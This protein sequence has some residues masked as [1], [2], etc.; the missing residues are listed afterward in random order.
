MEKHSKMYNILT[1]LVGIMLICTLISC[2]N[3]TGGS[4]GGGE[5]STGGNQDETPIIPTNII[6]TGT[7]DSQVYSLKITD[8][9][10]SAN[11]SRA[12]YTPKINDNYV[13]TRGNQSNSG[14][15]LSISGSFIF[16]LKQTGSDITFAVTITDG[17][18]SALAGTITWTNLTPVN[19]IA[20]DFYIENLT[21]TAENIIPVTIIPK[22]GKSTGEITVLYNESTTLPTE[23]GT[24]TVTF[25]VTASAGWNAVNGLTG[26]TLSINSFNQN[27]VASDF[28]ISN[29]VQTA[30]SV[31]PVTITPQTGKS[32]GTITVYYDWSSNLPTASGTYTVTFDVEAA[33]GWNAAYQLNGGTLIINNQ[34]PVANDFFISNL[35]QTAGSVT[36]VAITPKAGK[37]T[38]TIT[39]Y[40]NGST[41]LPTTVG[42]YIV[43]FNVAASTGWNA[44]NGLA[45][46][47]LS[48]LQ[49]VSN[50]RF[51][52]YWVNEHGNLVTTSG[53]NT[54]V[55]SGEILTI[56]AQSTGY[57]VK[58]WHLNGVNTG[59][60]G[61]T[62]SFSSTT[63]GKHTIGLFVEKDGRLYN[64]NINI[65]VSVPIPISRT[66]KIDMYDAYGDGWNASGGLRIVVNGNQVANNVTVTQFTNTYTFSAN[67]GDVVQVYWTVGTGTSYQYENSF[68][69]F[70]E[71]SPPSPQFYTGSLNSQ[72][73]VGPTSWSGTGSLLHRLRTATTSGTVSGT[74]LGTTNG[75]L[76]GSFTVQ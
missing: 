14:K 75:T 43:T 76:L 73:N 68:I 29:L 47:T 16:T 66:I 25:N 5:G 53:G 56:T 45:G 10:V 63:S 17:K 32:T 46:G 19:P 22:E 52:Y 72:N 40:Y 7:V 9:S 39:I 74:L 21:Q 65:T 33:T 62:Y 28:S 23:I 41:T 26:G 35:T 55:A 64:T 44:V 54:T 2:D 11:I 71:N 24:Y 42:I 57:I 51:E 31:T 1:F 69:I 15:V 37:S 4:S 49:A 61:N 67:T 6:Y 48:I 36:T 20:S 18:V 38:G 58:Q 3:G 8:S 27:P 59:Q 12:V 70:Y 50:N 34:N 13:L 30:G 60:S